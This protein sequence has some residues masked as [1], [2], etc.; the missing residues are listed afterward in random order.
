MILNLSYVGYDE[1]LGM[2]VSAHRFIGCK[3]DGYWVTSFNEPS[4]HSAVVFPERAKNEKDAP[5][6]A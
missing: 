4:R 3:C 2:D 5:Y 6:L 1:P